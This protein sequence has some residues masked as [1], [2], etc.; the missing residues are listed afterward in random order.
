MTTINISTEKVI[1]E[2]NPFIYGHFIEHLGRCIEDGIWSYRKTKIPFVFGRVREDVFWAIKELKPP[3]LRW[4]GGCFSDTYH[5]KD[6][7]G[8]PKN[9]PLR[10][11]RAWGLLGPKIGPLERN[12]F[13]T[14]EFL[15]LCEGVG[16]EPY[17]NINFGSGTPKEAIEW[18]SYVNSSPL[19][20][21][22]R[23]RK[24]NGRREPYNVK[25]WGIGNEIFGFWEVGYCKSGKDYGNKYLKF[26]NEMKK[27]DRN[28]KVVAVGT[29]KNIPEWNKS[30]LNT[31]GDKL[32]FLSLHIY[33][34]SLNPLQMLFI[35]KSPENEKT[36]YAIVSASKFIESEI[37]WFWNSIK[38]ISTD[39][40]IA[41]D[42]WNV[43]WNFH[44]IYRAENYSIQEGIFTATV[45]NLF[46]KMCDKIGI[47]NF[48][49][50]VNT[51]GLIITKGD[52][53][54]LTP[55]Y[56]VFKLYRNFAKEILV[57]TD[58]KCETYSTKRFGNI[59]PLNS[60]PYLDCSATKSKDGD[61]LSLI[62]TNRHIT[63]EIEAGINLSG[64]NPKKEIS[65]NEIK[66]N[67]PFAKNTFHNCERIKIESKKI[68]GNVLKYKFP[69]HSITNLIWTKI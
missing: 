41:F 23:L 38:D 35:R 3:I 4:P 2:I 31:I 46:Q 6:G 25:Y 22:G 34:P 68:K 15:K 60:V 54:Y 43:W 40:K 50:L 12:H 52:K 27:A 37:E 9:R 51:L 55:S 39:I 61:M 13:G 67:S 58:V 64:F 14:D 28:I 20:R 57:K 29:D 69:P 53:L 45:L 26:Y 47:V 21:W 19:S 33:V 8:E 30:L 56:L 24:K 63:F 1:C 42:E 66:S 7:I 18:V 32:D 48:A 62:V 44:D 11:N 10:I 16:A 59:P 36:Y 49:Q 65:V 17:I 5:W